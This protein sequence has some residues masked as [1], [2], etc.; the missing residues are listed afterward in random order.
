MTPKYTDAVQGKELYNYFG[1]RV[2]ASTTSQGNVVAVKHKPAGGF[3]RSEAQ[4]MHY[5]SQ[6]GILAPRVLGSYDVEPEVIATVTDL[7]PGESL[8][9]VWHAMNKEQ[10]NSIKAQL[11]EQIR[12]FQTCT[13]PYIGRINHQETFNF[14]DRLHFRFMGPFDTE[15]EFDN[16]CLARVKSPMAAAMWKKL[17]PRMRGDRPS[18]FVLTHGDLAARNIMVKDGK[19]TGIVDWE[20]SAFFPEYMEYALATV[21]HDGHESWW[22][23]VLKEVL[24]PCG[25]QRS[26]FTATIKD[27]GW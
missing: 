6:Q 20:Y 25:F 22:L 16:W 24:E 27:R 17:L 8:D 11:K 1:N 14:Y 12:L 10:R 5:A 2:V 7:V 21:I 13:Q 18:K 15:E 26:R 19:I 23:P 4:M 3:V 9:K